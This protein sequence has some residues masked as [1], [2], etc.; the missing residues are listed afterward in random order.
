MTGEKEFGSI[1]RLRQAITFVDGFHGDGGSPTIRH[2]LDPI[3]RDASV[4]AAMLISLPFLSPVSMGPL[5]APASLLIVLLGMQLLS[6]KEGA[7][8]PDRLLA[9][10]LSPRI[11]KAMDA[12]L[13]RVEK[14]L[15]RFSRPRLPRLVLGRAGKVIAAMGIIFGAVLLAIPIPFL[16]LTNTLPSLGILAFG[17]GWLERDGLLTLI[18]G[19]LLLLTLALF[20]ALALAIY[21]LGAEAVQALSP[22]TSSP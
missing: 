21:Y 22:F 10:P 18:G 9:L 2:L 16:P 13:V 17:F 1:S 3:G 5:T 7:P 4:L 20:G 6:R 8:L 15:R 19:I 11:W 12:V 14:A